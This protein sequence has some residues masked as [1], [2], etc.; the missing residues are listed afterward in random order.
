[1]FATNVMEI[2]DWTHGSDRFD[3]ASRRKDKCL[4]SFTEGKAQIV[5]DRGYERSSGMTIFPSG[6]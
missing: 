4:Y 1:M 2:G 3:L 5:G 6:T